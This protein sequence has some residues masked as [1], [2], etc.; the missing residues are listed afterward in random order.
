MVRRERDAGAVV[1]LVVCVVL[2]LAVA[3][4]AALVGVAG[5]LRDAARARSAADAA[6]LASVHE[7]RSAAERL[8]AANGAELV[9]WMRVDGDVVVDVRVGDAVATAR[10]TAAP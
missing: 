8:A 7:G 3:I 5:T 10:A 9:G 1:V 4:G 2:A 6:A